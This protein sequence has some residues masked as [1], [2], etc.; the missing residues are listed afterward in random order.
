ME[1][2]GISL[3][4]ALSFLLTTVT[5]LP[6][7]AQT[8]ADFSTMMVTVNH[9][10]VL[11]FLHQANTGEITGANNALQRLQN[12]QARNFAQTMI[13]DHQQGE[14]QVVQ[15]ANQ[16]GLP[17]YSY[18]PSTVEV[19][20]DSELQQMASENFDMAYLQIALVDHQR[21][22][23]DLKLFREK[24]TDSDIQNL[25]NQTI[26]VIQ[27]HIDLAKQSIAQFS[28]NEWIKE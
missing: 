8:S 27:K 22:L 17:L 2:F 3:V 19:A 15:L 21:V 28:S 9:D 11:N 24:V 7:L 18:Q 16:K 20:E 1:R 25:V 4:A 6:V 26:A 23:Q 5:S 14:E 12:P 10:T 13:T